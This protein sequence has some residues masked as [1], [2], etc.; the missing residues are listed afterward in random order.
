MTSFPTI[1][2]SG[3]FWELDEVVPVL[4][5]VSTENRCYSALK[6]MRQREYQKAS[7]RSNN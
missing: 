4:C 2:V 1:W 6:G 5:P 7:S 3:R